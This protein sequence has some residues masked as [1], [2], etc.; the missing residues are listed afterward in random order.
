MEIKVVHMYGCGATPKTISLIEKTAKK[1]GVKIHLESIAVKT[2]E[3]AE[4]FRHIGSPTVWIN[5]LD[6]EP[7]ARDV[8]Q[9]GLT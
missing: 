9:F 4:E 2:P 1:L 5:G 8:K 6:I 7:G 3:E